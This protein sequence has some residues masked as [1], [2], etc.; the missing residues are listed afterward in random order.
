MGLVTLYT[1]LFVRPS[2]IGNPECGPAQP[3]LYTT[4]KIDI[5]IW[6]FLGSLVNHLLPQR[7][8]INNWQLY[9]Y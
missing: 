1:S 4:L 2:L 9:E 6:S 3:S 8:D 5:F 7:M